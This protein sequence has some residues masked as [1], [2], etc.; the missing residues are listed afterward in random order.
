MSRV[1][2]S[3]TVPWRHGG[4]LAAALL[5]QPVGEMAGELHHFVVFAN[6]HQARR[7]PSRRWDSSRLPE[8]R[9]HAGSSHS[10]GMEDWNLL[11]F[12]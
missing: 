11:F 4:T 12:Q 6:E 1:R 10:G 8:F 7:V 9:L 3:E 2:P 5:G